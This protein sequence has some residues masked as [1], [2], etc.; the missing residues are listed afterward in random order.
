VIQIVDPLTSSRDVWV[1]DLADHTWWRLTT[2]GISD[3]PVWTPDGRRVVDSSN[4]DLWWIAADGSARPESLLVSAGSHFAGSVTPDGRAVVF[5]ETG[6]LINGIR[7]LAFDSAP[8]ARTIIPAAFDESAPALSPDGRWLAYQSDQTGRMEV[9]VQSYPVPG[10]R[11]S[12]SL[13]GG[14]EPVWA[15]NGRE[16]FYRAGDSLMVASVTTSGT[17]AVSG[18]KFLFTGSFLDGGSYR[19]YDV[20]PDDQHFVM[21]SGGASQSTLFGV[22]NLFQRLVYDRGRQR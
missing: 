1:L 14:T 17:F 6:S 16:L 7:V 8:A 4:D 12:I 21:I 15:H 13:K 3:K 18:R 20:A 19:D 2:N 22:E 10:A 11:V 9:Y 5:Q